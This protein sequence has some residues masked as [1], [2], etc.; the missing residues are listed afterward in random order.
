[1]LREKLKELF[2]RYD[3]EIQEIIAK[4]IALEQEHISEEKPRIGRDVDAIITS[5]MNKGNNSNAGVPVK[6]K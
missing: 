5:V 1:M 4:V 6:E 3:P 2:T